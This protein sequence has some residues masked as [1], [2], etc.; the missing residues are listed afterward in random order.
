M[1]PFDPGAEA[2][3]AG[4]MAGGLAVADAP[5]AQIAL[6][7]PSLD[8]RPL[9][10]SAL[11]EVAAEHSSG[12]SLQAWRVAAL[13]L[14][15]ALA[16]E[17]LCAC[18]GRRLLSPGIVVADDLAFW[19]AALR[20]AGG[21]VA[22]HA[23]LPDLIEAADGFA[24][25][26][27]PVLGGSDAAEM[28]RLAAAMPAACRA[29]AS[30][31]G[32]PARA[33]PAGV[34][35]GSFIEAMIDALVRGAQAQPDVAP[36]EARRSRK[37]RGDPGAAVD[38][39]WLA[40]LRAPDPRVDGNRTE[41]S[42]LAARVRDWR[43]PI[44]TALASPFRLCFRIEEPVEDASG[45][46]PRDATSRESGW[47]VRYL[48]QASHDP[49][50][51]IPATAAWARSGPG[52][53]LLRADGF[54]PRGFLLLTL[55]Q[56]GR[57]DPAIR[58]SLGAGVPDGYR[59]DATGAVA[60]LTHGAA[61]LQE[62]GFGVMLPAWWTGRGTAT[63]L[64]S[65]AKVRSPAMQG[66]G[67]LSLAEVMDF[68]W[69]IALGEQAISRAE[70]DALVRFKTPLV[71]LR[72]RWVLVDPQEIRRALQH[73]DRRG[74][75]SARDILRL[76]LDPDPDTADG[77]PG[78]V[79]ADGWIAELLERL[80]RRETIAQVPAPR[81]FAGTL[82]P[83]QMRGYGWLRFLRRWGLGAC[84]ADD[85]G[86][87]KTIQTLAHLQQDKDEARKARRKRPVTL[88]VCPTSVIGNW[89]R[90]AARFTPGLTVMVHH[91]GARARGESLRDAVPGHDLVITSY[92]L[93]QCDA[94]ALGD[95]KWS[96]VILDEAQNIKNPATKQARAARG[97]DSEYRI[98]LTGTP[99][100]NNVGELWSLM[101]F[102]NPGLLGGES[103]FKR[104]FFVPIQASRDARAIERL[105]AMTGP[106]I[107]RRLKTD[108]SV[109]TDLPAKLEMKVACTL[110]R[111][112][113]TLYA[114]VVEEAADAI[115]TA[116][117]IRRR[118]LVLATLA[119]LKQVCN[120]PAQFLG[121]N[122]AVAGRSGKLARL[123]EMIEEILEVGER[124]LV[125]TQF[126]EMGEIIKAHLEQMF[127]EEVVFL[128]GGVAK[129]KR[130]G[131]VQRFQG[132][133]S[134]D[135]SRGPR[136][137]LLSLKAGGT[138]LN[139]TAANHVFHFDRWWNPAVE[140]Q[141]T[142]RAFRI[143]QTRQVQVH[144]FLCAGTVEEKID[145]MIERKKD[146]AGALVGTGEDWLTS[147]STAELRDLFVLRDNAVSA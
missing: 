106:F 131:M 94:A 105:R 49:S 90:E 73:L 51:M 98:A 64:T 74:S 93:L 81:S 61:A 60:F 2:L 116:D 37:A 17:A 113:A 107:L 14:S 96:G 43:H 115:E 99:V 26:W 39:R 69:Q 72:G 147:L 76:A 114:A 89:Q 62:A 12:A 132:N 32:I 42:Q 104:G 53:A 101:H 97:L 15:P 23:Y 41:L 18:Q 38:Q 33:V 140:D 27:R 8:G 91:G 87:G 120:H 6:V 108:P 145:D 7:L 13:M 56:A 71:R 126:T 16:I 142:D 144:K 124:T 30:R 28:A 136:I 57:L 102:L 83:Y 4:A 46:D 65:R 84:L 146:L 35:L 21:L 20:F 59:T 92:S 11:I 66:G 117:G 86:L 118:G 141:A 80:T 50:L 40:A 77:G 112:Q 137:F 29:V 9:A 10:S 122:S 130:D 44:T 127:G 63:R 103:D 121:D 45:D 52:K 22:R 125:F 82:R 48:L 3:A 119:K 85:M 55:G 36:A 109:I 88:L 19:A 1:S 134:A 100:E 133:G 143:G 128:H 47:F 135:G 79:D 75:L 138:G 54:D 139:L 95:V 110:T 68:E 58:D 129:Q 111:E 67:G 78:G 34:L 70:L 25:R 5:V 123:T 31:D 24:S